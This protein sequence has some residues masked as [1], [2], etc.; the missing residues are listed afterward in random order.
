[1]RAIPFKDRYNNSGELGKG[2][3]EP[4]DVIL[5][6]FTGEGASSVEKMPSRGDYLL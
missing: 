1:V 3:K 5:V 4:L 2:F 6:L